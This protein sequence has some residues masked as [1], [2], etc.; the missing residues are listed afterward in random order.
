MIYPTILKISHLKKDYGALCAVDDISFEIRPGE[1]VGLLGPNGAGKTTT[2]NMILGILEPSIALTIR[3]KIK[4]YAAATQ[5]AILWTSHNMAEIATV[6]NRVL[7]MSHG[8]ILLSGDPKAL[9][10]KHGKKDLEELFIAVARESLT[11]DK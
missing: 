11:F 4:N 10:A 9:P 2:I 3:Q 6:C 5:A 1:I 8:K 7:F